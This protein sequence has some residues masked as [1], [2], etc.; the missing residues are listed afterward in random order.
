M[1]ATVW[2]GY[3]TFGLI[4]IPVRLFSGA[5]PEH[6][7]FH[8]LHSV[9]ETRIKQQL[10]CPHCERVV[11]RDE[12]VKGYEVEKNHYVIVEDQEIAKVAPVSS[13]AMEIQDVVPLAEI[14]PIFFESSYYCVPETA[15]RKAYALLFDIMRDTGL[16]AIA[17]LAMHRREYTVVIRPRGKGL[18]LHTMYYKNEVRAIPEYEDMETASVSTRELEMGKQL[19]E[20][21]K[22]TFDPGKYHD[23]Y[24][25]RL[26]QLVEARKKGKTIRATAQPKLA[27]VVDLMQALQASLKKTGTGSHAGTKKKASHRTLKRAS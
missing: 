14:D 22:S 3:I 24:Q 20:S 11:T 18:T 12:I 13:D 5:R 21:M 16:A 6:V 4:S 17:Q 8:Q 15:G 10:Y 7:S 26:E 1:A 25:K 19:L 9:C 27:P 2:T 23:E